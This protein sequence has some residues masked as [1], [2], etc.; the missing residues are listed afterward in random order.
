V[1]NKQEALVVQSLSADEIRVLAAALR[2]IVVD[3][4]NGPAPA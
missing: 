2:K 1:F 3:M 4:E